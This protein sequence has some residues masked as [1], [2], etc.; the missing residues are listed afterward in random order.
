MVSKKIESKK[1]QFT[2]VIIKWINIYLPYVSLVVL[3]FTP[4]VADFSLQKPVL[5]PTQ[6][7]WDLW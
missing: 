1:P 5:I 7:T 4:L 6:F 3:R 2:V